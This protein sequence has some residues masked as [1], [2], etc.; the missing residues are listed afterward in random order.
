MENE[1]GILIRQLGG[2]TH[3]LVGGGDYPPLILEEGQEIRLDMDRN[4]LVDQFLVPEG[5]PNEDL[6]IVEFVDRD[7]T[8]DMETGIVKHGQD[9]ISLT[10]T[11]SKVLKLL[12]EKPGHVVSPMEFSEALGHNLT[13]TEARDA[14]KVY[15]KR[16]RQKIDIDPDNPLFH[17]SRGRG[18][19]TTADIKRHAK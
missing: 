13:L 16:I 17:N 9:K 12:L 10:L 4:K 1:R 7:T 15:M 19:Y 6:P 18:Y 14:M 11:E 2:E 8:V 3:I 5:Q